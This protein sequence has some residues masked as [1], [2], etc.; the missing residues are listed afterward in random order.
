VSQASQAV[1]KI[2]KSDLEQQIVGVLKTVYDPEIPVNIYD[3]GL[4]YDLGIDDGGNVDIQ[5]TL[6]APGCPVA[7]AMPTWVKDAVESVPGVTD[8]HVEL[9]WEPPWNTE[10][11]SMRAKL[12]LNMI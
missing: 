2:D 6:T 8:A 5:M 11:M 12:E 7:G 3:L 10:M 9:V 4:I 1:Q